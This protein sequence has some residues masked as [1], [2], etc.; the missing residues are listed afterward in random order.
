ME[1]DTKRLLEL[2]NEGYECA[3]KIDFEL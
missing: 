1:R 2:Y 3:A